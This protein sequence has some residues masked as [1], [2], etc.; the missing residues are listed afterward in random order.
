MTGDDQ[1]GSHLVGTLASIGIFITTALLSQWINKNTRSKPT[2]SSCSS[3]NNNQSNNDDEG[4]ASYYFRRWGC[5]LSFHDLQELGKQTAEDELIDNNPPR[6]GTRENERDFMPKNTNWNHF[7]RTHQ[8]PRENGQHRRSSSVDP[9]PLEGEDLKESGE[10]EE[11]VL[12]LESSDHFVWTEAKYASKMQRLQNHRMRSSSSALTTTTETSTIHGLPVVVSQREFDFHHD[13]LSSQDDDEDDEQDN[14]PSSAATPPLPPAK[15]LQHTTSMDDRALLKA[16]AHFP[17]I[18]PQARR[19]F[20]N[21]DFQKLNHTDDKSGVQRRSL[22]GTERSFS[23]HLRHQNRAARTQYNAS[24]MPD[25]LVLIRHGQSMGNINES[26]YSTTPD[27][28]M[29]LTRLGWEQARAAGRQLKHKV[30]KDSESIHFIV[31][32]YVRTVETFHGIVSA[33]CDPA[34]FSHIQDR[35]QRIKAWYA[36]LLSLGLTWHEDPRIR[37]QDCKYCVKLTHLCLI[38]NGSSRDP[39]LI[40]SPYACL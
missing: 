36:R 5:R 10:E 20:S 6:S 37:E 4:L 34:E 12:T 9:N 11:S 19:T 7:E 40:C 33:W 23:E 22:E 29:P 28:A 35:D 17:P 21:P 25:K 1:R 30:L 38:T 31:S 39:R 14:V 26:L 13:G 24:I 32:P 8:R 2:T 15:A 3:L 18:V 16:A 27:N